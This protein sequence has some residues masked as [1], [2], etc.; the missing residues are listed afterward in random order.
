LGLLKAS[1][2]SRKLPRTVLKN[3]SI[4]PLGKVFNYTY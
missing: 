4:F 1:K 3:L 2:G